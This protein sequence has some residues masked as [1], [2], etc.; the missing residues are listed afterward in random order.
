[1]FLVEI[2]ELLESVP[3]KAKPNAVNLWKQ[4]GPINFENCWSDKFLTTGRDER[5]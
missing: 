2:K 5:R 1:M 3:E 4:L